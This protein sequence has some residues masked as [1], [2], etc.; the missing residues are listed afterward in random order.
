MKFTHEQTKIVAKLYLKYSISLD[1]L[2]YTETFERMLTDF[3]KETGLTVTLRDFYTGLMN[4]RKAGK[5][6]RITNR[7]IKAERTMFP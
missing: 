3:A 7:T 6:G 2:P 4:L 1:Q 5:L